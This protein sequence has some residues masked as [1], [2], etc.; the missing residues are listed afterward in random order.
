MSKKKIPGTISRHLRPAPRSNSILPDSPPP[1]PPPTTPHP[2]PQY[3]TWVSVNNDVVVASR[4]HIISYSCTCNRVRIRTPRPAIR[5]VLVDM[6]HY[7]YQQNTTN[8]TNLNR[9]FLK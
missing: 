3:A 9:F 2:R 5:I 1:P 4:P 8:K 7:N 6:T